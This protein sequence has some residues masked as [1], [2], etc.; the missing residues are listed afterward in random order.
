M[1]RYAVKL[2]D[3]AVDVPKIFCVGRNYAKHA[4]EMGADI[5]SEPMLFLK[6]RTAL[7][8]EPDIVE[9]PAAFGE[10]HH[11]IEL[12]VVLCK[13][14]RN[15]SVDSAARTIGGY[16][17]ALDLTL[18]AVQAAAKE[19]GA[20]W[21]LAKGFDESAP[22]GRFA[23]AKNWAWRVSGEEGAGEGEGE[24]ADFELHLTVNGETKQRGPLR[25]MIF[26]PAK[27]IS[28][29]SRYFTLEPG[30]L[31]LTG[32]PEGVGPLEDG[33]EVEAAISGLPGLSFRVKRS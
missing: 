4:R 11:E 25:E 22:V 16:G 31:F 29:A 9:V 5:P 13:G 1:K 10:L 28:Y 14:G 27:L 26:S 23:R 7:A 20:P 19:K 30:D 2:E 15:L 3:T 17:V 24:G 33:D 18:R 21:T 8:V 32:T 6:P 12:A